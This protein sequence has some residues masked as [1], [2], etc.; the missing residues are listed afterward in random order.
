LKAIE[1]YTDAEP[2]VSAKEAK[3]LHA[4]VVPHAGWAFSGDLAAK[5]IQALGQDEGVELVVLFGGHMGPTSRAWVLGDGAWQTPLGVLEGDPSFASELAARADATKP[6]LLGPSDYQPDNTIELQLP[7]V[8]RFMGDASLVVAGVPASAGG[9]QMGAVAAQLA[10]ERGIRAVAVGSTDLTHYGINYDFMPMGM[11]NE[12]VR[13]VKDVN[14]QR[15]LQN[16]EGVEVETFLDDAIKRRNACCPGAAGAALRFGKEL[17][18][19]KAK[20]L[21]YRTS[22]DIHPGS[23]FVGY[24]GAVL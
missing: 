4:G 5:V 10:K 21:G 23:S 2:P 18:A 7:F 12:A 24:V 6:A 9:V 14:D 1:E 16:I 17:G 20:I 19:E 3:E 15:A 22:Y 11:G 13:W 8:K